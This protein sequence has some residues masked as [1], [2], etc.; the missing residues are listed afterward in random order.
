MFRRFVP[1][2]RATFIFLGVLLS[3]GCV[4]APVAHIAKSSPKPNID[5]PERNL[6]LGLALDEQVKDAFKVAP[7]SGLP[8]TEV[9]AWRTTL[10]KGFHNG[11]GTAFHTKEPKAELT[12]QLVEAELEFV[13]SAV[14]AYGRAA[15]AEAHIRYK[16]R[17]LDA[18]GN[19]LRRSS[20]TVPS[21]RSTGDHNEYTLVAKSAVETMY[22][23]ISSELFSD[24]ATADVL[25]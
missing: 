15:A 16:A 18:S 5:L 25:K 17:L 1:S 20:G 22:E 6:A 21:K 12:L 2:Y 10:E 11:L 9:T 14:D 13:P 7:R 3:L 24:S 23:R 19:V 8:E 4:S